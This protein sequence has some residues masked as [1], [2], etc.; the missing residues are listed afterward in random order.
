MSGKKENKIFQFWSYITGRSKR[1]WQ[2]PNSK[3]DNQP[4]NCGLVA[5]NEL[6]PTLSPSIIKEAF[7]FCCEKYKCNINNKRT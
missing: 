1:N 5:L 2:Y 6:F 7:L 3:L 4:H